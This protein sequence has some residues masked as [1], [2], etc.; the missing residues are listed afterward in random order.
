M[1][2]MH[3][4][5]PNQLHLHAAIPW[6]IFD[7]SGNLLLRQGFVIQRNEQIDML[8]ERHAAELARVTAG[9]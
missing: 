5:T 4:L 9:A 7:P 1:S 6:D 2:T 8:L 3:R